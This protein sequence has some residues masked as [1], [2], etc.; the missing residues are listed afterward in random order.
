[1][2]LLEKENWEKCSRWV[3]RF[4]RKLEV[5][6]TNLDNIGT[7]I[8]AFEHAN[9]ENEFRRIRQDNWEYSGCRNPVN[10]TV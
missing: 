3:K 7:D 9:R 10:R 6:R 1:M 4:I 5:C 2:T 8:C